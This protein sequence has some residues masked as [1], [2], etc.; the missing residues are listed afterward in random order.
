MMD[1]TH[2]C[3]LPCWVPSA[4]GHDQFPIQNLP[5]AIFAPAGGQP[6]GGIAI[7]D[8]ILDVGGLAAAGVLN[9]D[10][11]V[12]AVAASAQT[13]NAFLA[14]GSQYRRALRRAVSEV[15]SRANPAPTVRRLIHRAADCA[16][17]LPAAVGDY[18]DFY[19]GIHHAEAVGKLFRPGAP[20]LPNY[21]YVP[22]AY[23]GRASSIRVSGRPVRRPHGQIKLSE[24]EAPAYAPTRRLDFELELGI[25]V[26][27]GSPLG[28]PVPIGEAADHVAGY[29]L[30]NDWSA[31]DIQAWEY[32]PL[33][34][35]LAKNFMTSV[36]PWIVSPEALE[37]YRM[38]QPP[39]PPGDPRPL[40]YLWDAADQA[41]GALD[42][43]L[44]VYLGTERMRRDG[45]PPERIT[46]SNARYLYWTVAQ[47]LA[48]HTSGGCDL[49]AGDLLGSGTVSADAD[50][51]G[52]LLELSNGGAQPIRLANGEGRTFLLDGD[53]IILTARARRPGFA[54]VGFGDCR[55]T[56]V[57]A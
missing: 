55:G 39:R 45:T 30:L 35:F 25:W 15:L 50:G 33:G 12:A 23:H 47:M 14:L 26:G 17:H 19:A 6:R 51:G 20:L 48:H 53:E 31:R 49:R 4:N 38:P 57:A 32:Q 8:C 24:S 11:Q 29:G 46:L 2:D 13:L 28:A 37:P 21:K 3:R 34:P 56:I 44:E 5:I 52:S 43:T 7:G 42:V 10:S 40:D 16:L 22:V 41:H 9:G 18:T 54:P 1:A 27:P 36:S